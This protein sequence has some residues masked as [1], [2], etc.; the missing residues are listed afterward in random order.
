MVWVHTGLAIGVAPADPVIG[1]AP[2]SGHNSDKIYLPIQY[3]F[4][5]LDRMTQLRL[6]ERNI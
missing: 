1:V 5:T 3:A 2:V 4:H 6:K